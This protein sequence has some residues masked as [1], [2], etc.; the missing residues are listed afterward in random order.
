MMSVKIL[1]INNNSPV[2]YSAHCTGGATYLV[3]FFR[4]ICA[5][6]VFWKDGFFVRN[7]VKLANLVQNRHVSVTKI[8]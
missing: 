7:C 2:D 4:R 1:Y 8:S 6:F 3:T 5:R